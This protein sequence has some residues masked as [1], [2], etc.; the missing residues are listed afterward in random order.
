VS[1]I[2][3]DNERIDRLI[4]RYLAHAGPP[5]LARGPVAVDAAIAAAIERAG[6]RAAARQVRLVQEP[7]GDEV[8]WMMDAGAIGQALDALV[9]N[10][11]QASAPGGEVTVRAGV[12]EE[13]ERG[14]IVVIDRGEGIAP[15]AL[16]H[17][18]LLGQS[19]WAGHAGVGLTVA[20]QIVKIHGGS[21]HAESPGEG[22]GAT[23]RIEVPIGASDDE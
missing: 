18:F 8:R 16:P 14:A 12:D 23:F 17:V 21:L 3:R 13:A 20:K 11:I 22:R 6:A 1:V 15:D 5:D 7:I 9:D 10:A 19:G 2:T 4:D